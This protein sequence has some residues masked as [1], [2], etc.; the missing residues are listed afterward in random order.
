MEVALFHYYTSYSIFAN[1]H[2]SGSL[3][4]VPKRKRFQLN[5]AQ[6]TPLN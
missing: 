6:T 1:L 2:P 5:G 3:V 4:L